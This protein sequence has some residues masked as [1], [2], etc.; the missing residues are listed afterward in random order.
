M[1]RREPMPG[2]LC[3]QIIK[4]IA[5]LIH[6]LARAKPSEQSTK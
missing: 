2:F 5:L 1:G 4:L 6:A 3:A